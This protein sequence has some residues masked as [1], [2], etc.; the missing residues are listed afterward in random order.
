M[1]ESRRLKC[2][3]YIERVSEKL[4]ETVMMQAMHLFQI[5]L[6]NKQVVTRILSQIV[7]QIFRFSNSICQLPFFSFDILPGDF[8]VC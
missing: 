2:I 7:Q 1:L 5:L 6:E 8:C 3:T 4:K